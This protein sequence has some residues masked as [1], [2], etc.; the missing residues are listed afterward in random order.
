VWDGLRECGHA[1]WQIRLNDCARPL[2]V[3]LGD[4]ARSQIT[5]GNLVVVVMNAIVIL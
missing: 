5:M 2:R 3:R 1:A 4:A